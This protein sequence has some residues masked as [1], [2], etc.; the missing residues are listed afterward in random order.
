MTALSILRTLI[1]GVE[2]STATINPLHIKKA[3]HCEAFF[4]SILETTLLSGFYNRDV[5]AVFRAFSDKFHYACFK[6][7]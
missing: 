2:L 6:C 5:F 7:K 3:P 1:S 4:K